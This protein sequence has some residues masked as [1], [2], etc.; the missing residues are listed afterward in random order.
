MMMDEHRAVT[1]IR[2][3]RETKV[4]EETYPHNT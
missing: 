2:I 1:G 3:G 4:L